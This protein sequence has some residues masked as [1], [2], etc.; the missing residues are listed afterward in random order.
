MSTLS[1]A[2]PNPFAFAC[3]VCACCSV[4]VTVMEYGKPERLVCALCKL[5]LSGEAS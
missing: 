4:D 5:T 3:L 2:D 1:V